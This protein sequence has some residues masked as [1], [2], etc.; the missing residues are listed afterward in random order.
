MR[1][2]RDF[3]T[4]AIVLEQ[5]GPE[6]WTGGAFGPEAGLIG[7]LALT[8]G[9]LMVVIWVRKHY[10]RLALYTPIAEPPSKQ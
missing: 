4:S 2:G 3:A 7:L 10:D 5:G 6:L 8:L 1:G 9:V